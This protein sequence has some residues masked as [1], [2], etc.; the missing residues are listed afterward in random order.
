MSA[1]CNNCAANCDCWSGVC[2]FSVELYRKIG[3][4]WINEGILEVQIGVIESY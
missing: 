1:D 3:R 4:L 2:E